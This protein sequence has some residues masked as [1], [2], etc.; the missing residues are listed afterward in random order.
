MQPSEPK[1][2]GSVVVLRDAPSGLETLMLQRAPRG[3]VPG[4]WV[5]PGGKV[6]PGDRLTHADPRADA[7]R[8]ALRETREESGL[9]L[10]SDGLTVLSRWITPE[11]RPK[12]FDT[13]FF[14][15]CVPHSAR[16]EVDGEEMIGF[17]WIA[18]RDALAATDIRMAPPQYVSLSWLSEFDDAETA[19]VT[20][21]TRDRITFRPRVVRQHDGE[22]ILYPGDAGFEAG[23]PDIPGARHRLW[24]RDGGYEYERSPD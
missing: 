21:A 12:R 8:A 15:A 10:P 14:L 18:P 7:E 6:E 20:F 17:R 11:V 2:A 9:T 3:G 23:N 24:A 5:F 13:W 4:P 22:C 16:V 1:P 19:I